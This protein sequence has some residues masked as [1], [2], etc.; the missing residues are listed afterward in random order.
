MCYRKRVRQWCWRPCGA[1]SIVQCILL[2]RIAWIVV[3]CLLVCDVAGMTLLL[4]AS[5]VGGTM[6]DTVRR[7][8][9]Q[10]TVGDSIVDLWLLGLARGAV[11]IPALVVF[12]A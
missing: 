1:S 9:R 7:E 5:S 11:I 4:R 8:L 3:T 10:Y 6:M 12:H 2:P